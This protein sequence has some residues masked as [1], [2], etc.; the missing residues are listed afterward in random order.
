MKFSDIQTG[1]YLHDGDSTQLLQH[2]EKRQAFTEIE[3][4]VC[5][6]VA[7]KQFGMSEVFPKITHVDK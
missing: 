3:M 5:V 1:S 2:Q 6:C 4:C 7:D